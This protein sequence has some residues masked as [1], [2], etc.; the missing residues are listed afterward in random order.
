MLAARCRSTIRNTSLRRAV[1]AAESYTIHRSPGQYLIPLP[2]SGAAP[3]A[4]T[5]MSKGS[6]RKR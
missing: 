5:L 3:A 4:K 2:G 1:R 6:Y